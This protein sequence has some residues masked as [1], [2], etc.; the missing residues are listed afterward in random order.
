MELSLIVITF[1]EEENLPRCL[2]SVKGV[3]DEMLVVD[4]FSTD[5]TVEVARGFGARVIQR[6]WP[7]SYGGQVAFAAEQARSPWVLRLDAD[8]ALSSELRE[9]IAAWRAQ[10]SSPFVAYRVRRRDWAYGRW[11]RC[12]AKWFI[13]LAHR[14]HV[15]MARALVHESW[16]AK[17]S[18]GVLRGP[19]DH[20]PRLAPYHRW[21]RKLS[22]YA[23]LCA[24]EYH[25]QGRR[26]RGHQLFLNPFWMFL[27]LY[28]LKGGILDGWPGFLYSVGYA[29]YV[30]AVYATL[31][32][33]ER[34]CGSE[35]A[36]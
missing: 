9:E 15:Q 34:S 7:G 29:G 32:E 35:G 17:G 2:A 3:V 14:E 33:M 26:F 21:I 4:S 28:L 5:G 22:D 8:E 12:S 11:L 24:Q 6:E 30:F 13:R 19:I 27:R 10:P 16:Q 36:G 20:F 25:E 1:N 18:V 23:S 31:W